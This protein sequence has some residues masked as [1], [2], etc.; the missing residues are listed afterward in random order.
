MPA[1]PTPTWYAVT[2]GAICFSAAWAI[3]AM[4]RRGTPVR[5]GEPAPET[6]DPGL[7]W[8]GLAVGLWGVVGWMLL[9]PLR[10]GA[11][12]ASRTLLSSANSACLLI[13]AAH[14]DYGP[15]VLQRA[16]DDVRY[17]PAAIGG[18]LAVALLTILLY[19]ILG[20][21][22]IARLPDFLLSA[23]TLLLY[24]LGLFRSFRSRGF[25]PL[26]LLACVAIGLQFVAQ[27]PEIA[28]LGA[29]GIPGE[30]RWIVNLVSKA[31]VLIL[32]LSLAM[33]WVHEVARRPSPNVIRVRF[34]GK[35][36]GSGNR[37]RYEVEVG[38][39]AIEVRETPHRDLLALAAARLREAEKPDGGWVALPDLVGR[40]DDSRIRRMREDLRPA[41]LDVAIEANFQKAYRLAVDPKHIVVERELLAKEPDLAPIVASLSGSA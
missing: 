2:Q 1:A 27:L 7:F 30:W 39:R 10:E 36:V 5:Q 15:R 13:S 41:G 22:P 6:R 29:L 19:A 26:A 9:L 17:K 16:R 8:M 32:F 23:V 33:T 20:S 21:E 4:Y 34:T 28:D 24:G 38:E 35:R 12:Q 40:L 14:L 11:A 25:A 31:M 37:R 18:S 3:L